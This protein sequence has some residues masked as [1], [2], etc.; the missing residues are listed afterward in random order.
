M[1]TFRT[2]PIVLPEREHQPDYA[3]HPVPHD[4]YVPAIY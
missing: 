3:R 1:R 2:T 4:M